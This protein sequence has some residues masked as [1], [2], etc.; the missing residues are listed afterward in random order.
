VGLGCRR[1]SGLKR[2][3]DEDYDKGSF[4]DGVSFQNPTP[5]G[6]TNGLLRD[7]LFD[8]LQYLMHLK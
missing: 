6:L 8:L 3:T 1:I 7:E 2:R 4:R 5:K